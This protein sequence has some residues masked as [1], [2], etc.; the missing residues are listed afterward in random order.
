MFNLMREYKSYLEKNCRYTQDTVVNYLG[1][2]TVMFDNLQI[3][4]L[5]DIDSY[6]VSTAW[7][8]ARWQNIDQGIEVS[9]KAENGYL[10]A[11]KEFL[12]YIEDRGYLGNEVISEIIRIPEKTPEKLRGL[13]K[14]EYQRLNT[15][16][17]YHV[18]ND[19]QRKETALVSLI[20][21]TG[22]SITEA[23]S[24]MVHPSGVIDLETEDIVSG[25]FKME[26]EKI[27]VYFGGIDNPEWQTT[28][29]YGTAVLINFYLENRVHRN[30]I[31]FLNSAKKHSPVRLSEAA[32]ERMVEKVLRKAEIETK[33]GLG[34]EI[35]RQTA[36]ANGLGNKAASRTRRI[37]SLQSDENHQSSEER[38]QALLQKF[39][40]N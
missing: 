29:P 5:G 27:N 6:K 21:S 12:R 39:S 31:M 19:T 3:Q 25:D 37:I 38:R 20:L 32:A 22:C 18:S 7:R 4:S 1:N 30:S 26:N 40:K 17:P 34:V 33:K 13:N 35:L 28:I 36:W 14:A 24:L 2:L 9:E 10:S 23:L 16:L 15:F 8:T 11:F